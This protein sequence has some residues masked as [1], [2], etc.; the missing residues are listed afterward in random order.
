MVVSSSGGPV[1]PGPVRV[2]RMRRQSERGRTDRAFVELDGKRI[3][4]GAYGSAEAVERYR[5]LIASLT[6]APP[7][8]PEP[9]PDPTLSELMAAYL[10]H[11]IEHYGGERATE[12][13]HFRGAF[14][15]LRQGWG[16]VRG[17]DFGPKTFKAVRQ[18]MVERGWTRT[19]VGDQCGRLKRFVAWC[20]EEELVPESLH[21]ALQAVRPL[22][23]GTG[24]R[25][26]RTVTCVPPDIVAATRAQCGPV[27]QDM[28]DLMQLTGARP[29]ELLQLT[30]KLIDRTRDIWVFTPGR[31]K[32]AA[33][34]KQRHIAIGPRAQR[35]LERYLFR[36]RC[37]PYSVASFRRAIHRACDRAF[38]HPDFERFARLTR[39]QR[40][41]LEAWRSSHRWGPHRLR[42]N[43]GTAAREVAGLDGAQVLLGHAHANTTQIYAEANLAKAATIARL[44]G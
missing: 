40:R 44:I 15:V 37:F 34:G 41:E 26:G 31:H 7:V 43:A 35:I 5:E 32:T 13:V 24:V 10:R 12:V 19:Y 9:S 27:V 28:I 3:K 17:R 6:E 14:R 33:K 29:G 39:A 22:K 11:A 38:P 2:P 1:F 8:P 25:E 30:P 18:A 21:H 16:A 23:A 4:L 42:H 36:D 20:V